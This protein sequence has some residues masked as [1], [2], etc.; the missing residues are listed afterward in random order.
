MKKQTLE[1]VS[2]YDAIAAAQ[3]AHVTLLKEQQATLE[4]SDAAAV[5]ARAKTTAQLSAVHAAVTSNFAL[6]LHPVRRDRRQFA[7]L[8]VG[9]VPF[10]EFDLAWCAAACG[11]TWEVDIDPVTHMR[12]HVTQR[13]APVGCVT[14]RGAAPLPRRL[15]STGASL[16][17]QL[18]SYRVVIEAYPTPDREGDQTC[19]M[20]FVPSH[21]FTDAAAVTPVAGRRIRHYGGWWFQ[22]NRATAVRVDVGVTVHGWTPLRPRAAAGDA[23]VDDASTYATTD[24]VPVVPAGNAVE[25][26][27][28]YAARTCR[29]AFYTPAA[30]AGGFV[31]APYAK[32]ELRFVATAAEDSPTWGAVP[33]RSVPTAAD[34]SVVQLYPAVSAANAGA[35]LRF[36]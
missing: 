22:V 31:E 27:V 9:P 8:H 26:S 2:R 29:V 18:P 16:P 4:V 13:H 28:D 19:N 1:L 17:P 11:E 30:V 6:E 3:A 34:S 20:G 10:D 7:T 23:A 15:P 35:V 32:M 12:A 5:A 25:L 24:V 21:T 14:L 36:V 33:A